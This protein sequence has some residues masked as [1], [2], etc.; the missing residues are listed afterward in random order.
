[1]I[2]LNPKILRKYD[3]RGIIDKEFKA[4]DAYLI[5]KDYGTGLGVVLSL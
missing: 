5:G 1:M 4:H 3:I 2:M